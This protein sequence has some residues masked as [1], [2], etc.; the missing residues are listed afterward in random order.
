MKI[1]KA[2][3]D[4]EGLGRM[5]GT[6]AAIASH[7]VTHG[8]SNEYWVNLRNALRR[9]RRGMNLYRVYREKQ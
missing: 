9:A 6:V 8:L 1:A 3:F 7:P 5:D 4:S 2:E